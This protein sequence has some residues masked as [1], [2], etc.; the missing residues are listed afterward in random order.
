MAAGGERTGMRFTDVGERSLLTRP[1]PPGH[2]G[3]AR[4]DR[5]GP[6]GSRRGESDVSLSLGHYFA[7]PVL[8]C[9]ACWAPTNK[10]RR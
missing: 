9:V 8:A 6:P 4:R 5:E 7:G 10:E 2:Q 3:A 1:N